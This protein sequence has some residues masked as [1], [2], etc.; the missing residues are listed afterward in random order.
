MNHSR[1]GAFALVLVVAAGCGKGKPGIA[2][3]D[4]DHAAPGSGS[5]A[6]P[7]A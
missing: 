3:N 5:T 7:V 1:V 4:K 6:A 2:E